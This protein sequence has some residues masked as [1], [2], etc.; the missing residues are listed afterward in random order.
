MLQAWNAIPRF[1]RVSI[2]GN[3][4]DQLNRY[5]DWTIVAVHFVFVLGIGATLKRN[6]AT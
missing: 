1:E 3:D 6:I 2:V 5:L 4:H